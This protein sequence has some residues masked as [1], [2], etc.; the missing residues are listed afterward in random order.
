MKVSVTDFPTIYDAFYTIAHD[1][2]AT[3]IVEPFPTEF[4]VDSSFDLDMI[5]LA[6][7]ATPD[8]DLQEFLVGDRDL[9]NE[10]IEF[11]SALKAAQTLMDKFYSAYIEGYY[12]G[13]TITAS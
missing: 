10:L 13:A 2:G 5:E 7:L 8:G 6:L 9:A 4:D 12:E 3:T 1:A 11:D